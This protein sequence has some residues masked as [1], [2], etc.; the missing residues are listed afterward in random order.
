MHA[1]A[2]QNHMAASHTAARIRHSRVSMPLRMADMITRC[3]RIGHET[4]QAVVVVA[5]WATEYSSK[6]TSRLPNMQHPAQLLL[7]LQHAARSHSLFVEPQSSRL[8]Q[9][10][11]Q[12][13]H[14]PHIKHPQPQ[15][16]RQHWPTAAVSVSLLP[17]FI[18]LRLINL[19]PATSTHQ[20]LCVPSRHRLVN[21]AQTHI[22]RTAEQTQQPLPWERYPTTT[23]AL[24]TNPP[25]VSCHSTCPPTS[26]SP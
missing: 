9:H 18:Y 23:R 7:Q 21:A 12:N 13:P 16:K 17:P 8:C 6:M 26:S 25:L 15:Q 19:T 22:R 1:A 14:T 20:W 3:R 11:G 2:T 4:Q 24:H 10:R 5:G